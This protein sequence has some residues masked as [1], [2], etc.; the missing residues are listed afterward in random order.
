MDK[1]KKVKL[2]CA[3]SLDEIIHSLNKE[4]E[5][6]ELFEFI[7]R[8]DLRIADWNFTERLYQHFKGEHDEYLKEKEIDKEIDKE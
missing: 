6:D 3:I 7:T 1:D 4:F 2:S 8:L 5:F